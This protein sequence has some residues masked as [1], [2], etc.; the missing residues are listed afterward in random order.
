MT[1]RGALTL[2]RSPL[3]RF[4]IDCTLPAM[5]SLPNQTT[6]PNTQIGSSASD[7][8]KKFATD[9]QNSNTVKVT[10]A[11]RFGYAHPI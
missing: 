6:N 11:Q 7:K 5:N 10:S 9:L 1:V 8:D 3:R 2:K 4:S